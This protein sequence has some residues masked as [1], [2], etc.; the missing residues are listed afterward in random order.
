M[1]KIIFKS[2]VGSRSYGTSIPTSDID[3]KGVYIQNI[4]ELISFGYKEQID[5]GKDECYYEVRRFLQLLQSANPTVLELLYSPTDCIIQTSPQFELIVQN[6]DKFLTQKCLH[7]FGGYA[8][9]QI[10]KAKGLD[11]KMNWE[12]SRIQRK[13]P[14][15]FIYCY[16]NG[17]TIQIEKWLKMDGKKQE[18]CG[19]VSLNHFKDCYALYYDYNAH[20]LQGL[21]TKHIGNK[22]TELDKPT[23]KVLGFKGIITDNSNSIKLSSIPKDMKSETIIYYNKD[24]Y[25]MHCKDYKEYEIWIKNRNIQRYIDVKGHNQQIDG[26]NLLHCRRLLDMAMEIATQKTINVRRPNAEYLLSIRKGEIELFEIIEQAEKD[27]K[28]LDELFKKSGLPV[29]C[30]KDFVNDLLLQIRYL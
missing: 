5:I 8:I 13:T 11:K 19:L 21:N 2:I 16:V 12:K 22:N 28:E 27:I 1:E 24:G 10:K 25:S 26:K 17:K 14:L 9:A 29:D 23:F 30:D 20:Y 7:S 3:Y 4:N 18:H 15:D 6:R